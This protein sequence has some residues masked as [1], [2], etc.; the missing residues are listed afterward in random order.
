[1]VLITYKLTTPYKAIPTF[2]YAMKVS[3]FSAICIR[4]SSM[5]YKV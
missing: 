2:C 3:K 5:I 1:M 4:D